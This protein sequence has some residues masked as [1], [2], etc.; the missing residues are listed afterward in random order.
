MLISS[1]CNAKSGV[2][3]FISL[4]AAVGFRPMKSSPY[5]HFSLGSAKKS[6]WSTS[7]ESALAPGSPSP[8][9]QRPSTKF[10]PIPSSSLFES[11]PFNSLTSKSDDP[12][13]SPQVDR[14]LDLSAFGV[15]GAGN[16]SHSRQ[17][18]WSSPSTDNPDSLFSV[19][20]LPQADDKQVPRAKNWVNFLD[21][22]N[23]SPPA[24][25]F[26]TVAEI[27]DSGSTPPADGWSLCAPSFPNDNNDAEPD[28]V[29]ALFSAVPDWSSGVDTQEN[30]PFVA[31][32]TWGPAP[33]SN[34]WGDQYT[35]PTSGTSDAFQA[36]L[37]SPEPESPGGTFDTMSGY[38][39]ADIWQQPWSSSNKQ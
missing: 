8:T 21:N 26:K 29:D 1:W 12:R 18:V 36:G 38:N 9:I 4:A 16:A 37:E 34:I 14:P 27:W 32:E 11:T 15:S 5:H 24:L 28:P 31:Q 33:V 35:I 6:P 23:T 3:C 39:A 17:S 2:I 7:A 25:N 20:P 30:T 13:S 22:A 19:S 10:T